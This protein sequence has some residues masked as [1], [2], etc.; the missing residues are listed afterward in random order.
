MGPVWR[1]TLPRRERP[2]DI[3]CLP[4]PASAPAPGP[5][6]SQWLQEGK[7]SIVPLKWNLSR[8]YALDVNPTSCAPALLHSRQ[9]TP[10]K[11]CLAKPLSRG[12]H[13]CWSKGLH[14]TSLQSCS[15]YRGSGSC[16]I[17]VLLQGS[18]LELLLLPPAADCHCFWK[19]SSRQEDWRK[20]DPK[21]PPVWRG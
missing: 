7:G 14:G 21:P 13:R 4:E 17:P 18:I 5:A 3:P 2:R 15:R 19:V 20:A 10:T 6:W 12:P 1:C 16:R 11:K 9:C 8:T